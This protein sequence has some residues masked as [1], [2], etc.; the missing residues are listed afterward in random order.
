MPKKQQEVEEVKEVVAE[1]TE[2]TAEAEEG[3]ELNEGEVFELTVTDEPEEPKTFRFE[4]YAETLETLT[5]IQDAPDSATIFYHVDESAPR[6]QFVAGLIGKVVWI[7]PIQVHSF[8]SQ[9]PSFNYVHVE[10]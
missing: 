10:E 1:V 4:T 9:V 6:E 8:L 5:K 7:H 3:A 2:V